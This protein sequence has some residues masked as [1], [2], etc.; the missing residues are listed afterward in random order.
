MAVLAFFLIAA[1]A[2]FSKAYAVLSAKG[3]SSWQPKEAVVSGV[4][5]SFK[6]E[7]SALAAPALNKPF[8]VKDAVTLRTEIVKKYPMLADVSVKR[9][10]LSGALKISASRRVPVAKFVLPDDSV[11]FID[12]DSVV[13]ADPNPDKLITVPFVELEGPTPEKLSGEFV[14][15]VKSTLSLSKDLNFAFLRFNLEQNTVT[16]YMPDGSVIDFGAAKKLKQK[17][18]KAAR[19]MAWSREHQPGPRHIDFA[20]FDD[21]KVFSRQISN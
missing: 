3:V 8:S 20:F 5:G 2:A 21:G 7:L 14:D 17:A 16:M 1:Y 10:L 6:R 11:R 15:L 4:E 12:A 9:G 13:Y 18:A 19:I